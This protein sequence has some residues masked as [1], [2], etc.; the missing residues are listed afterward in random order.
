[1]GKKLPRK[2]ACWE[3]VIDG[4]A[5]WEKN[6]PFYNKKFPTLHEFFLGDK[7]PNTHVAS[8]RKFQDDGVW[9]EKF[10]TCDL[11]IFGF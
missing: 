5:S 8:F 11:G 4:A 2:T 10:P 6:T 1:M 3:F 9:R 7:I